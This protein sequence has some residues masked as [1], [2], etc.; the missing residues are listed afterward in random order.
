MGKVVLKTDY[1]EA[2]IAYMV[3]NSP[4]LSGRNGFGDQ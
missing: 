3:W 4:V 1:I 2:S